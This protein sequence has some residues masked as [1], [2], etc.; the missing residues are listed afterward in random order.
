MA[1]KPKR[2]RDLT[3]RSRE[4]PEIRK[5]IIRD[6]WRPFVLCDS[7]GA[8]WN[9]LAI[10]NREGEVAVSTSQDRIVEIIAMTL[11]GHF[12]EE[13]KDVFIDR[14]RWHSIN[15]DLLDLP[16]PEIITRD[17]LHVFGT[18]D[19]LSATRP[20]RQESEDTHSRWGTTTG[21]VPTSWSGVVEHNASQPSSTYVLQFGVR[22]LWKVG[23]AVDL[24]A[25]LAEVNRHVP[26]EV[27]G[28]QWQLVLHHS[29]ASQQDAYNM[30]Q[31]VLKMLRTQS[32]VGERVICGRTEI[33]K[34]WTA[35]LATQS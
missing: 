16:N 22:D 4:H 20:P 26:H 8:Y 18:R 21:P 34:T 29:W 2:I 3:A 9:R 30:E 31:R 32:S 35:M 10:V 15:D 24:A 27:L 19:S 14:D 1:Y 12:G 25:R 11:S 23:H 17:S 28:E 13:M 6:G 7:A 5:G 33:E